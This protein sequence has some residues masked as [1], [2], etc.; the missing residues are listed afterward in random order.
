MYAAAWAV[1]LVTPAVEAQQTISLRYAPQVGQ[2][3]QTVWWFDVTGTVN[4]ARP[5]S[6][7]WAV[8]TTGLRSLTHRVTEVDGDRRVLEVTRDSVRVRTRPIDG[9]WTSVTDT[10]GRR[11]RA[12]LVLDERLR[13]ITVQALES[14]TE[15]QAA[16]DGFRAFAT[17]F[18]L[19]LPDRPV[20][21]GQRWAADIVLRL[22]EPTGFEE[23]PGVSTWLHR[24]GDLVVRSTFTLD[25]LVD[26]GADTLAFLQVQGTFLPTTIASAVEAAEGRARVSGAFAARMIWSTGWNA[27]VSGAM[28]SQ[29]LMATFVG[30][31]Q[32]EAPE[33]S[34]TLVTSNRFQ[35]R[36]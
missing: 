21:V 23:E 31:P 34:L 22:D 20:S 6:V 10:G 13:V 19:A 28:R 29:V 3:A 12:R 25:S 16:P 5:G 15:T 27:F 26:R 35:V 7:N 36:R 4:D 17:G 8:E 9:V 33:L 30:T 32:N 2:Y 11:P 24:V 18:E 14:D 1:L